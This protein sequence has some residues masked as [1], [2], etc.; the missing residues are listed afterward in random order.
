MGNSR[1]DAD[2]IGMAALDR[3]GLKDKG[4]FAFPSELSGGQQQ[5]VAIARGDR[6][7][8]EDHAV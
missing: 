2:R 4:A 7:G 3:V 6:A 5:R 8:A 1:A